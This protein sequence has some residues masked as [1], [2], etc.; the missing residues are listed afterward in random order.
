MGGDASDSPRCSYAHAFK[1]PFLGA[2]SKHQQGFERCSGVNKQFSS[3]SLLGAA[4]M[5]RPR[6]GSLV[7][8]FCQHT[9]IRQWAPLHVFL[10][11]RTMFMRKRLVGKTVTTHGLNVMHSGHV[12]PPGI[13]FFTH[14]SFHSTLTPGLLVRYISIPLSTYPMPIPFAQ[15]LYTRY[16]SPYE[17]RI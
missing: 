6:R 13:I 4:L 5:R 7:P 1:G 15:I 12:G 2:L 11:S 14:L 17:T 16:P 9:S 8:S 3:W 10:V